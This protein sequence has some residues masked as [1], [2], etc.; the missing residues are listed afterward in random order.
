MGRRSQPVGSGHVSAI[1]IR[2]FIAK[3]G[4]YL[5]VEAAQDK[6][7]QNLCQVLEIPEV[8]KDPRFNSVAGRLE[9]QGCPF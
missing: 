2:A 1:P 4:K 3:D 9:E 7:F 8:G 5:S 6:F